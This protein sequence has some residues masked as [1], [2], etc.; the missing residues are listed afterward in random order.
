LGIELLPSTGKQNPR[1]VIDDDDEEGWIDGVPTPG[2]GDGVD[3]GQSEHK[4]REAA[5]KDDLKTE[6]EDDFEENPMAVKLRKM[7]LELRG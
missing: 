6:E 2:I 1:R 3:A 7:R 4:R 5:G